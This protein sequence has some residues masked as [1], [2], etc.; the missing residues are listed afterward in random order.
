MTKS[1]RLKPVVQ[2]SESRERDAARALAQARAELTRHQNRQKELQQYR[3]EYLDL[4]TN[5]SG[6]GVGARRLGDY[7]GFL[8]RLNQA[9]ESQQQKVSDAQRT[10][11]AKHRAWLATRT[12]CKALD[13]AVE[14]Y[15]RQER[16]DENRREQRESDDYLVGKRR[17]PSESDV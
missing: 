6:K 11:E 9:I 13:R 14:N 1:K 8:V 17:G 3:E 10:C 5:E 7:H 4:L 2:L 12:R 15:E 16:A